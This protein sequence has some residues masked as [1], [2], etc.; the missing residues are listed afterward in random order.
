MTKEALLKMDM[1]GQISY[2]IGEICVAIRA[3]VAA[4]EVICQMI[5]FNQQDAYARGF[6]AGKETK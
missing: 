4:R 1:A 2:W 3:G 6:A 5:S